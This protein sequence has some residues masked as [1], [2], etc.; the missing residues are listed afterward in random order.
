MDP[1]ILI[2]SKNLAFKIMLMCY[3][4]VWRCSAV[5]DAFSN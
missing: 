1:S 5:E 2:L 4:N 3:L